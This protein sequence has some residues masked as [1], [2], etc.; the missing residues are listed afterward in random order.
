MM[1]EQ[2]NT[3]YTHTQLQCDTHI[4]T[5]T[6]THTH[7]Y[8]HTNTHTRTHTHTHTH[9]TILTEMVYGLCKAIFVGENLN[10][11][12]YEP[13]RKFNNTDIPYNYAN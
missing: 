11:L 3:I 9:Q 12:T 13:Q 1:I 7:T 10:Q 5:Y 4:H 2:Q 6:H 8:T